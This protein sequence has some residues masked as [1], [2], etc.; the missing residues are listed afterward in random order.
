PR[1]LARLHT[2]AH[3]ERRTGRSIAADRRLRSAAREILTRPF[4]T[5]P[6]GGLEE[7]DW[8]GVDAAERDQAVG[9]LR[10][11]R[12]PEQDPWAVMRFLWLER[13]S[14]PLVRSG[15][16][17]ACAA[18]ALPYVARL[19][20]A[21]FR[22]AVLSW[23]IADVAQAAHRR[24]D[25]GER[26]THAAA[27]LA[28]T[29]LLRT[30]ATWNEDDRGNVLQA[31]G[32]LF[33]SGGDAIL[34]VLLDVWTATPDRGI[35]RA[36]FNLDEQAAVKASQEA[37]GHDDPGIV[38]VAVGN[39]VAAGR[40]WTPE[41]AERLLTC[42]EHASETERV[43]DLLRERGDIAGA[44]ALL[45]TAIETGA[46]VALPHLIDAAEGLCGRSR[47]AFGALLPSVTGA[48]AV[49]GD[50]AKAAAHLLRA[51]GT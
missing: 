32:H 28:F 21:G 43:V 41:L 44:C 50:T 16:V 18:P 23:V 33:S 31:A 8:P 19:A 27:V 17:P 46:P 30:M 47:S 26:E 40:P 10:A 5:N 6:L 2:H 24:R 14:T 13:P 11:Q 20:E 7:D 3:A 45:A 48:L 37:L 29:R 49:G 38:A 36:L 15:Q 12:K 9:W 42:R 51:H 4:P 25:D 34:P 39:L 35:L 1:R 22:R